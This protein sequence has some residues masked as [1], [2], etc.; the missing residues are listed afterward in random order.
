MNWQNLMA[1]ARTLAE[2]AVQSP[3]GRL[4]QA[5]L[6]LAE[7]TRYTYRESLAPQGSGDGIE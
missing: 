4:G 5:E 2:G 3:T 1:I 7:S 6:R